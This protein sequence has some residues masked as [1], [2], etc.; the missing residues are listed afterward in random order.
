MQKVP[1]EHLEQV[2]LINWYDAQYGDKLL[3]AI[4]NGGWR[5]KTTAMNLK[6]EGVRPGVPDLFFAVPNSQYHGLFIE[7]KRTKN[8]STSKEQKEWIKYLN[9]AGYKAVVCKGWLEAK[10]VIECYLN[11]TMNTI[12]NG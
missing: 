4:P 9:E 12:Q 1:S 3:F 8:S 6:R 11:I 10:E 2:T 7:M 5:N